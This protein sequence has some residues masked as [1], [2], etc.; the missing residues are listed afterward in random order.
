MKFID[1]TEYERVKDVDRDCK[2]KFNFSWMD[3]V[4]NYEDKFGVQKSIYAGA[5][6]KKR[7]IPGQSL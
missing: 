1:R 3:D 5:F 4:I 2:I 7:D 6:L